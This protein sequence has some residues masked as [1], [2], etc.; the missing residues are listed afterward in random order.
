M[1]HCDLG[2]PRCILAVKVE[3]VCNFVHATVRCNVGSGMWT[4]N[5]AGRLKQDYLETSGTVL[6]CPDVVPVTDMFRTV[7]VFGWHER[8]TKTKIQPT[9]CT[10]WWH[11]CKSP[12]LK[13]NIYFTFCTSQKCHNLSEI[14]SLKLW[15]LVLYRT[16]IWVDIIIMWFKS[17]CIHHR[18]CC[19]IELC[20]V[21][22]SVFFSDCTSKA[23]YVYVCLVEIAFPHSSIL[24]LPLSV[25]H[26]GQWQIH[27]R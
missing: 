19:P 23:V 6:W 21:L 24:W 1:A 4:C 13:A 8:E 17:C 5:S 25:S 16:Y 11:T 20:S 27:G 12:H 26:C 14:S 10:R 15:T 9:S 22:P 3:N 7:Y 2:C 18:L